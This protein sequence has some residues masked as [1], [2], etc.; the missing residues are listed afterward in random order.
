[1]LRP[2]PSSD[3]ETVPRVRRCPEGSA[4][5]SRASGQKIVLSPPLVIEDEQADK[6]VDVL[7]RSLEEL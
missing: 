7:L 1:L 6:V 5:T 2:L 3:K 4:S